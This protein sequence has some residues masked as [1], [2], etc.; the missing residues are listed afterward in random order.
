M[1][2][3]DGIYNVLDPRADINRKGEF[4]TT[5]VREGATLGAIA[6]VCGVEIGKHAFIAA[7]AVVTK[8][9]PPFALVA[10]VPAQQIGWVDER[11]EGLGAK[12]LGTKIL[13]MRTKVLKVQ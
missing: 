1:W 2:A 13:H 12:Y 5:T 6:V 11:G 3:I 7:G 9:V 4:R 10:G 8:N